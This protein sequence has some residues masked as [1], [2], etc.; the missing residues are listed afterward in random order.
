M[1]DA[2]KRAPWRV[3]SP[4]SVLVWLPSVSI[5]FVLTWKESIGRGE[6]GGQ[7]VCRH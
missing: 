3:N 7:V 5:S 4:L 6:H 1:T 2:A